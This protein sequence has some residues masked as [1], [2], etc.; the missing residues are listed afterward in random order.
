[1]AP[2]PATRRAV[3]SV[4]LAAVAAGGLTGCDAFLGISDS[5]HDTVEWL[6]DQSIL[7]SVVRITEYEHDFETQGEVRGELDPAATPAEIEA[8]AIEAVQFL[9]TQS[10]SVIDV[11]LG[12]GEINFAV[13]DVESTRQ[14]IPI[15]QQV[16]ELP[17]VR[18][19][20]VSGDSV[21][22]RGL[23]ADIR[24]VVE[25][26][27]SLDV[28]YRAQA[29]TDDA[30]FETDVIPGAYAGRIDER[31]VG[32]VLAERDC[33]PATG[34]LPIALDLVEGG[35][36]GILDLCRYWQLNYLSP[37]GEAAIALRARLDEAGITDLP[38]SMS[39][40]RL[41]EYDTRER[42][43]TVTPGSADGLG[44]LLA[45]DASTEFGEDASFTL[46]E[47]RDLTLSAYDD[48]TSL[49]ADLVLG[50][51]ASV[52]VGIVTLSGEDFSVT[53][54]ADQLQAFQDEAQSLDAAAPV[55]HYFNYAPATLGMSLP[56]DPIDS[57][58]EAVVRAA[59]GAL[60]DSGAWRDR[61]VTI[62]WS[63]DELE[64]DSGDAA[65]LEGG[66]ANSEQLTW[67]RDEWVG[68]NS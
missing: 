14:A 40:V 32:T 65:A 26:L 56:D 45:I 50:S 55:F 2:R 61:Q 58:P 6:E 38:V 37:I 51:P 28:G 7:I 34:V 22:T 64:I 53:A 24:T 63:G 48:P 12:H 3:A 9:D 54:P 27:Q 36:G 21:T 5:Y 15:W 23:R 33:T 66:A 62:D 8:F 29:L 43:A 20:L 44:I 67:F 1:M 19:A 46:D 30:A 47:N 60:F 16:E 52:A 39:M 17:G 11:Y 59:A 49:L 41:V 42:T 13:E 18:G 68:L 31:V 10:R 57:T 25:G 4:V 35:A